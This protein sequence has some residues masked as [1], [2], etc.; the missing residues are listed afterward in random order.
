[1]IKVFGAE[2]ALQ[3]AATHAKGHSIHI[4][5]TFFRF[6]FIDFLLFCIFV[7]V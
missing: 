1:M 4:D 5:E 2:G 7:V 3:T 6:S